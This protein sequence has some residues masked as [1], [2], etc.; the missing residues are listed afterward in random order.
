MFDF[1][2]GAL[3]GH[4]AHGYYISNFVSEAFGA[5]NRGFVGKSGVCLCRMQI[6]GFVRFLTHIA[7][8]N[9]H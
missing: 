1:F 2:Q 5:F 9:T 8:V 4:N 7:L 3:A 6:L